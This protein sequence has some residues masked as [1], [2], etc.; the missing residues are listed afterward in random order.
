M[1]PIQNDRL[2]EREFWD[3][4]W[5]KIQLPAEVRKSRDHSHNRI[6]DVFDRHLPNIPN[7]TALEIGGAPGQYLAYLMRTKKYVGHI[8]D[9]SE[10]GCRKARENFK[11]LRLPVEVHQGDL[12]DSSLSLGPFD[13]VFSLGFIEHFADLS[14]VIGRHLALLRPGG[15]LVVGCPNFRGVNGWFLKRL[16]PKLL[17]QHNTAMMDVETWS[18]FEQE[19]G[20]ETLF[21]GYV[22]GFEPSVF[23]RCE[24]WTPTNVALNLSARVMRRACSSYPFKIANST[25][26]SHYAIAAYRK[27]AHV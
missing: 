2:T 20:L 8:L 17:A 5:S 3:D 19:F 7:A 24:E 12:F 9:Y 13:V 21:R 27:P 16:A 10:A 18:G 14:Q 11:L 6:L 1:S 15:T 26:F 4:Y 23:V 22:G 25:H